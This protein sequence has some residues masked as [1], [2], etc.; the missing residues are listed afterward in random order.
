[1]D[2]GPIRPLRTALF[3]AGS[4]E[5]EVQHSL[6]H[7]ADAVVLDIE[8]PRTPCPEPER[9]RARKIVGE[10]LRALPPDPTGPFSCPR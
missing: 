8:E 4:E 9:V 10:F 2:R 1:M 5:D 6:D 7:G 3:V